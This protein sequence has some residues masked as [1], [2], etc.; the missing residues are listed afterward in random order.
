MSRIR[1]RTTLA[2]SE[3]DFAVLRAKP[4]NVFASMILIDELLGSSCRPTH[5]RLHPKP[6][7]REMDRTIA[8]KVDPY[9]HLA[10]KRIPRFRVGHRGWL[11]TGENVA[12]R[13]GGHLPDRPR[14]I[15]FVL[16]GMRV[17][18]ET[19]VRRRQRDRDRPLLWI[20][21]GIS[22]IDTSHVEFE[23]SFLLRKRL[24]DKGLEGI[25]ILIQHGPDR[26]GQ[27][28]VRQNCPRAEA[29]ENVINRKIDDAKALLRDQLLM[30]L[31]KLPPGCHVQHDPSLFQF[32]HIQLETVMVERDKHV[33]LRFGA[34]N[35]FIRD[36]Q[37]NARV[38]AFYEGGI[39]AV[40]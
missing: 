27:Q 18:G 29:I 8:R 33:H 1:L 34:A 11:A 40:A 30:M 3:V 32:L 20:D 16:W 13:F 28:H 2:K 26:G 38:P 25:D 35:A 4:D 17:S 39:L 15:R 19:L 31:R 10:E 12:P 24:S 5:R 22:L 9:V 7:R 21:K 14:D 36:V 6:N 23:Q 37:L